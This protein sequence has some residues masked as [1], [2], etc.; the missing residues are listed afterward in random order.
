M[1]EIFPVDDPLYYDIDQRRHQLQKEHAPVPLPRKR[2][3][4]LTL[5]LPVDRR[6]GLLRKRQK[7]GEQL[8]SPFFKLPLEVRQLVYEYFFSIGD[9]EFIIS[10]VARR[11]KLAHICGRARDWC[12][13]WRTSAEPDTCATHTKQG[14]LALLCTCQVM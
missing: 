13:R 3:R 8:Q 7:T 12:P 14:F 2:P 4:A 10:I 5:P 6:I 11:K 9:P 1:Q